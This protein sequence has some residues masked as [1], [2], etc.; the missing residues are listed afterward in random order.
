MA[1]PGALGLGLGHELRHGCP[2]C[3][4]G[5]E[6]RH[7]CPRCWLGHELRHGCPRCWLGHELRHGCPRCSQKLNLF[8][9][10]GFNAYFDRQDASSSTK[11]P[12]T[13]A[14]FGPFRDAPP[15]HL[16]TALMTLIYLEKRPCRPLE[17]NK[18]TSHSTYSFIRYRVLCNGAIL[19]A[20]NLWCCIRE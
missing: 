18:H 14:V 8:E 12:K 4:L 2:R 10:A 19:T 15:A 13:P 5:H 7:G 20:G 3:W 17:C 11:K 16:D 1:V 9:W 6:L